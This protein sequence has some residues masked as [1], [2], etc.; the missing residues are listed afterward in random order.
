M[1][2][3]E[4]RA[5]MAVIKGLL[6]IL[7]SLNEKQQQSW[8]KQNILPIVFFI[9]PLITSISVGGY[10]IFNSIDKT[11]QVSKENQSVL[12]GVSNQIHS[13]SNKLKDQEYIDKSLQ[14]DINIHTTYT[15]D[16]LERSLKRIETKLDS[17]K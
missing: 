14:K 12:L 13:L 15:H 6:P 1:S 7:D 9:I 4:L 17:I 10:N 16:S 11:Q 3:N 8:L 2:E 5:H